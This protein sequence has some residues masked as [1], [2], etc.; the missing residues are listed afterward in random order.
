MD[1]IKIDYFEDGRDIEYNFLTDEE[2]ICIQKLKKAVDLDDME[3]LYVAGEPNPKGSF[4]GSVAHSLHGIGRNL[5]ASSTSGPHDPHRSLI[6]RDSQAF[7]HSP[8]LHVLC[9][10][11]EANKLSGSSNR[12]PNSSRSSTT[13]TM[14]KIKKKLSVGKFKKKSFRMVVGTYV[15][16]GAIPDLLGKIIVDWF[17]GKFVSSS[18]LKD[19]LDVNWTRLLR[20]GQEFHTLAHGW[21]IFKLKNKEDL[22]N[23]FGR[24]WVGGPQV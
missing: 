16:I 6:S 24:V 3:P 11:S 14:L 12:K 15:E 8:P 1:D 9:M 22:S 17:C 4:P 10:S 20:Y 21:I 13:T 23:I 2:F 5:E 7:S 18:S 19:C